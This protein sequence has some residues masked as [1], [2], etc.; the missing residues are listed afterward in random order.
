MKKLTR[1][2]NEYGGEELFHHV[3]HPEDLAVE[4]PG[5]AINALS[6]VKRALSKGS[7]KSGRTRIFAKYDGAPLL[8]VGH[9]RRGRPFVATKS[10]FNK[11]PKIA[12]THGEIAQQYGHGG[13]ADKLHTA[14]KHLPSA[15]PSK[16][17]FAGELMGTH[18]D[19]SVGKVRASVR[20]NT[21]RYS[22][23]LASPAGQ[24]LSTS[25]VSFVPHTEYRGKGV[26]GNRPK[27]LHNFT[28]FGSQTA[29]A[30]LP[31][32]R[33]KKLTPHESRGAAFHL[34]EARKIK[35]ALSPDYRAAVAPHANFFRAYI[36]QTVRAGEKPSLGGLRNHIQSTMEKQVR[37]VKTPLARA[38]YQA[39]MATAL[40]HH[41][42]NRQHFETALALHGHIQAA[43]NAMLTALSPSA[44]LTPT[45]GGKKSRTGEGFVVSHR[46]KL[47]KLVNRSEFSRANFAGGQAWNKQP[48]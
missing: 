40:K 23:P 1:I 26:I 14:L 25:A 20:P 15:I 38:K 34:G 12:R 42:H 10:G 37:K 33:A 44:K 18:R 41:D 11:A 28:G 43:K 19:V 3:E 32:A 24:R 45:I 36:N 17:V 35:K 46:G 16:G 9:D 48:F 6:A 21:V 8:H 4:R 29:N 39:A 5:E 13:K 47:I 2:L 27:T 22:A 30:I 31:W 7:T